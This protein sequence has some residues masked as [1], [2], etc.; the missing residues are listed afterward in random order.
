MLEYYQYTGD[1]KFLDDELIPM[2][3]EVLSYYDTRFKRDANG[4][5]IISPTQ[6]VET[7]WDGVTND[8]PS[9]A[10][11]HAV[12]IGLLALKAAGH[13]PSANS[14]CGMKA[15]TPPLPIRDGRVL[16]AARV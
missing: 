5:L 13:R 2:A 16:P 9:V 7:Y 1:E 14:G 4:K 6:A 11:L 12:L 15:A 8:T 10:G 3:H